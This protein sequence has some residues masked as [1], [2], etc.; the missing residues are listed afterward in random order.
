[1]LQTQA[2]SCDSLSSGSVALVGSREAGFGA[3]GWEGV[4]GR[5]CLVPDVSP[6]RGPSGHP[7][8]LIGQGKCG[9]DRSVALGLGDAS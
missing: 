1:M 9:E 2:A 8:L 4:T 5:A 7:P 3:Q 6:L